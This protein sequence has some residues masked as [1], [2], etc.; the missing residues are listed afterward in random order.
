MQEEDP[1]VVALVARDGTNLPSPWSSR[2]FD[3]N[4]FN[5]IGGSGFGR[6]L[7][8]DDNSI[9][10]VAQTNTTGSTGNQVLV[11]RDTA[12]G[13][14]EVLEIAPEESVVVDDFYNYY[15]ALPGVD[16]PNNTGDHVV[17]PRGRSDRVV[18]WYAKLRDPTTQQ[19]ELRGGLFCAVDPGQ[20]NNNT[21]I[22]Q[23]DLIP[24]GSGARV[25]GNEN[26]DN[27]FSAMSMNADKVAAFSCDTNQSGP[28]HAVLVSEDNTT[29]H[30]RT[31]ALEGDAAP[32]TSSTFA[33]LDFAPGINDASNAVFRAKTA[34]GK[35][36]IWAEETSGSG[37]AD[38]DLELV[39]HQDDYVPPHPTA[40]FASFGDPV[41]ASDNSAHFL[42][43]FTLNSTAHS[44]VFFSTGGTHLE[45]AW[46]TTAHPYHTTPKKPNHSGVGGTIGQFT[47]FADPSANADVNVCFLADLAI[48]ESTLDG[49]LDDLVTA[50]LN[51][52]LIKKEGIFLTDQEN[53]LRAVVCSGMTQADLVSG[54]DPDLI[55]TDIEFEHEGT[56]SGETTTLEGSNTGFEDGRR[57]AFTNMFTDTSGEDP[58]YSWDCAV[59]AEFRDR[60]APTT[61]VIEAVIVATLEVCEDSGGGCT[62]CLCTLEE[63]CEFM[64]MLLGGGPDFDS[65]GEVNGADLMVTVLAVGLTEGRA[66]LNEDGIVDSADVAD[67]ILS[68]G[69]AE[70]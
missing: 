34:D 35:W 3:T 17:M 33:N 44:G 13:G 16:V 64:G 15:F 39:I 1:R 68:F 21:L 43:K 14:L 38:H 65:S 62:S 57:A 8:L 55:I 46:A 52:A 4:P 5:S 48:F 27:V 66:D 36:G 12:F 32:G 29:N 30:Y 25:S 11:K 6:S 26:D 24:G 50:G 37:F 31:V 59:G 23:F 60:D 49:N 47:G 63:G 9:A 22:R 58:C 61:I 18:G 41:I 53:T 10:F 28:T 69:P 19:N 45:A 42:A 40:T 51:P 70:E 7:L 20:G 54:G 2:E 56:R 67:T